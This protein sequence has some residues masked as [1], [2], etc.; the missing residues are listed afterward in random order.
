[1]NKALGR[2]TLG[3]FTNALLHGEKNTLLIWVELIFYFDYHGYEVS[4]SRAGETRFRC[5]NH[6]VIIYT[7]WP[8]AIT[9]VTAG[10][11]LFFV[12]CTYPNNNICVTT[13]RIS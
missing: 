1:V 6:T 11:I 5:E 2:L 10:N 3:E 12:V 4:L 13:P 9:I 8:I 7:W